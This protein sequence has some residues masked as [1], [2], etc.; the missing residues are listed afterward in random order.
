MSIYMDEAYM[1]AI[2]DINARY[3]V[4]DENGP[5]IKTPAYNRQYGAISRAKNAYE[6]GNPVD[7][8]ALMA[9]SGYDI[10][11]MATT[12]AIEDRLKQAY[13]RGENLTVS[14]Q[15][16]Q[17]LME[18]MMVHPS[19]ETKQMIIAMD[20]KSQVEGLNRV[21]QDDGKRIK[22]VDVDEEMIAEGTIAFKAYPADENGIVIDDTVYLKGQYN[23]VSE[24]GFDITLEETDPP[25][26]EEQKRRRREQVGFEKTSVDSLAPAYVQQQ[27]NAQV[28]RYDQR[29]EQK[30]SIA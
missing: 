16:A 8:D 28:E 6:H 25:L 3:G 1:N 11:G 23:G 22:V 9:E 27:D 7:Y 12:L 17:N 5:A 24:T 19:Q 10:R 20:Q 2:N 13:A 4:D 29:Y 21:L 14:P 18:R 30:M 26:T 15:I